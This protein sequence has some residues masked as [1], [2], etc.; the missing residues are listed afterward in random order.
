MEESSTNAKHLLTSCILLINNV[1]IRIFALVVTGATAF[2]F[3]N[4]DFTSLDSLPLQL[5]K[6][7]RHF[8][9]IDGRPMDSG[10]VTHIARLGL[11]I[12]GHE[13]DDPLFVTSLGH[14]PVVLGIPWMQVHNIAIRFGSNS[15]NFGSPYCPSPCTSPPATPVVA[16]GN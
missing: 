4:K 16:E 11:N 5:L 6:E 8:E 2:A 7:P 3:I 12:H 15:L 1:S 10:A 14:Y 13:E 9:V